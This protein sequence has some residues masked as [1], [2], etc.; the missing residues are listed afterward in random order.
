[1]LKTTL[2]GRGKGL[3]NSTTVKIKLFVIEIL[4]QQFLVFGMPIFF[5]DVLE[6]NL[7]NK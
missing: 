7:L 1:M 5:V 3:C 4:I 2:R 6:L